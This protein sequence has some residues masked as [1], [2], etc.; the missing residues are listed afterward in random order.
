MS[1]NKSKDSR[2]N[3][4]LGEK[5]LKYIK[6]KHFQDKMQDLGNQAFVV[7]DGNKIVIRNVEDFISYFK[8][9][10]S[11]SYSKKNFRIAIQMLKEKHKIK[12]EEPQPS[13]HNKFH[14]TNISQTV[15]TTPRPERVEPPFP[16]Q[17]AGR[18]EKDRLGGY[19]LV[20]IAKKYKDETIHIFD[21]D[22]KNYEGKIVGVRIFSSPNGIH[23]AGTIIRP[24]EERGETKLISRILALAFD[25]GIDPT[26]VN[27]VDNI[28][29]EWLAVAWT[30]ILLERANL[31]QDMTESQ[32]DEWVK[33]EWQNVLN[34]GLN[35]DQ[36]FPPHIVEKLAQ[37]EAVE[38]IRDERILSK[39]LDGLKEYQPPV[40]K[41]ELRQRVTEL[42]GILY[43]WD[44]IPTK[45]TENDPEDKWSVEHMKEKYPNFFDARHLPFVTIDPLTCKDM[46]DAVYVEKLPNGGYMQ[47]TAI[48]LVS[49]YIQDMKSILNC[50]LNRGNSSYFADMV[51]PMLMPKLSNIIGSLNPDE[52]RLSF[53]TAV[54]YDKDG[55]VVNE[56][57]T[58]GVIKSRHKFAY[59]DV[60]KIFNNDEEEKAKHSPEILNSLSALKDFE[61]IIRPIREQ[62][63]STKF[64]TRE[65]TYRLNKD[66][67]GVDEIF[68]DNSTKAHM[69]VETCMLTAN[70]ALA[71]YAIENEI[72]IIY[73]VEDPIE[74]DKMDQIRAFLDTMHIPFDCGESVDSY[75]ELQVAINNAIEYAF[76]RDGE[77]FANI[78]SENIIK[79]L[80]RARYDTQNVGH[81]ALNFEAY[82]HSTSPIRRFADTIS[83]IQVL[84]HMAGLPLPFT[85][86][87][88]NEICEQINKTERNSA[89]LEMQVDDFLN[90][91][92]VQQR[93][94]AG[95]DLTEKGYISRVER[96]KITITT[97]YGKVII[98]LAENQESSPFRLAPDLMSITNN[99]TGFTYKVGQALEVKPTGVDIGTCKIAAEIVREKG[100]ETTKH[101]RYEDEIK[102]FTH[103]PYNPKQNVLNLIANYKNSSPIT[104]HE[105]TLKSDGNIDLKHLVKHALDNNFALVGAADHNYI[106]LAKL[107]EEFGVSPLETKLAYFPLNLSSLGDKYKDKSILYTNVCEFT[108]R[109]NVTLNI[110]ENKAKY[111]FL[112][113]G[114]KIDDAN[115]PLMQLLQHKRQNDIDYDLA[116]IEYLFRYQKVPFP[117]REI[118]Q[119]RTMLHNSGYESTEI[120]TDDVMALFDMHPN[121]VKKLGLKRA[122]IKKML[123]CIPTIRRL[124]VPDDILIDAAHA[125]G[126]L[127]LMAH[128]AKNLRRVDDISSA[129]EHLI[130]I[131]ID[132]FNIK[133]YDDP[134]INAIIKNICTSVKTNNPLILD[135]GGNDCHTL[136]DYSNADYFKFTISKCRNFVT[137]LECLQQARLE[138][139]LTHRD[140]NINL[141]AVNEF[142]EGIKARTTGLDYYEAFK[143]K[144]DAMFKIEE[145]KAELVSARDKSKDSYY[146]EVLLK[147]IVNENTPK[148]VIDYLKSQRTVPI[149]VVDQILEGTF[150]PPESAPS[151]KSA[152]RNHVSK[153]ASD[154]H[155][156]GRV[157]KN[158]GGKNR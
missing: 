7:Y 50:A 70:E 16:T 19:I 125:S 94:N 140:Y 27:T 69:S 85:T 20:P 132:G 4:F 92:Y 48:S 91:W 47:Y 66:R 52:D 46:D 154:S 108:T 119:Y 134:A 31:H 93:L 89:D 121:L 73:R 144:V 109:D 26:P 116:P 49:E 10:N 74:P 61:D 39:L 60:D 33:N 53:I 56:T 130:A 147:K 43:D 127:V 118:N 65:F 149:S 25:A 115:S 80:P 139:K 143:A 105:H 42:T 14:N 152:K 71:R 35:S 141:D 2:F 151:E 17:L 131:G 9:D 150:V 86:E 158:T 24:L 79:C 87:E 28:M 107:N 126:A 123:N 145:L 72:P 5:I 63:G 104:I 59:E 112:I 103:L 18:I 78:V 138:G 113:V 41:P 54:E 77:L 142:I 15:T 82:S 40:N 64:L 146:T 90:A 122:T 30:D 3:E 96:D 34:A 12:D 67:T 83:Q 133:E 155:N 13:I 84:S 51:A 95:E 102:H 8:T 153:N 148:E 68:A 62:N 58:P 38:Y 44:S 97:S 29:K 117:S 23:D 45:V 98:E 135:A 22:A 81:F 120:H 101:V 11:V 21:A 129:V 32:R 75:G 114:A 156:T 1:K 137:E 157:G 106:S 99:V 128:P 111:H 55:N 36:K 88:I 124:N 37:T 100:V 110:K 57:L 6:S 76:K 136:E